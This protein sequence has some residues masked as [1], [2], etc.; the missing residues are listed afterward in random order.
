MILKRMLIVDHKNA[1]SGEFVFKDG[2]NLIVS[3]GNSQGKSSLIKSIYHG[4]GFKVNKF[5]AD[6]D[7]S[8]MTIKLNL[9]N[10]RTKEDLY[11]VRSAGIYY[12]TGNKSPMSTTEYTHWLSEQLDIDLKLMNKQLN[13]ITSVA[14]PSA[15]ITPFYIDQDD[16][17]SGR[18]FSTTNELTMYK[19]VPKR[20][21]DYV[22]GISDDDE[23][24]LSEKISIKQNTLADA[25]TKHGSIKGA[26]MDYIEDGDTGS[27]VALIDSNEDFSQ[28]SID[29][30]ISL[31]NTANQ[32]YIE[33]K[34]ARLKHQRDY[35]QKRKSAAEYRSVLK[36]YED[37]YRVIKTTCK[38]CK[39]KLTREQVQARMDITSNISQLKIMIA[40]V[41]KD[42]SNLEVK[43]QAASAEEEATLAEYSKLSRDLKSAPEIKSINDYISQASKKRSQEEFVKI[44][45]TLEAKVGQ[46]TTE[47]DELKLDKKELQEIT[48]KLL[49][50]IKLA[51]EK[52]A[53]HLSMLMPKSN[54]SNISFQEF[55]APKSSGVTDNQTY[56]GIY[57]IYMRLV[58]EFGRYKLPF[59]IDS[60]IKNETDYDNLDKMFEATEGYLLSQKSQTIFSAIQSSVDRYM[61]NTEQY[62]QILLGEKLLSDIGYQKDLQE[63]ASVMNV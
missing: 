47:I 50:D 6:W 38:H 51:Y 40:S 5:P 21:F 59:C 32:R 33:R 56:F 12:A 39:S 17:W 27:N 44:I 48:L 52:Y 7:V 30:L 58:S 35:D 4:L 63:V 3:Q 8:K 46:L 16:S 34:A 10:E 28:Q 9:Y 37:D 31:V 60:F 14:Y 22:L 11:V 55:T 13:K 29:R 61:K 2:A 57:L 20:I 24:R 45:Q 36:M 1:E 41:D 26:F 15:L 23:M 62:H 43:V 54:I 25:K 18:L 42:I 49:E 53:T 19:D